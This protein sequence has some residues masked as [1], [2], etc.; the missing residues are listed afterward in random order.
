M[1][2]QS[3]IPIVP[4]KMRRRIEMLQPLT[5]EERKA[6]AALK[7]VAENWPDTLWLFVGESFAVMK[8]DENGDQA[9][10]KYGGVDQGY[11]VDTVFG[12]KYDGGAW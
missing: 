10:N 2:Y 12:F 4:L 11:L 9:M 7:K 3:L 6:I 1:I 8:V 5:K